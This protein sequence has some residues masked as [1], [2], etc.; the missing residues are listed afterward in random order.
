RSVVGIR[1]EVERTLSVRV[2]A[3]TPLVLT[4]CSMTSVTGPLRHFA[5]TSDVCR[6][7]AKADMNRQARS[8]T[9]I[10][11]DPGA[12]MN[13][14]CLAAMHGGPPKIHS[15]RASA[16]GELIRRRDLSYGDSRR[17]P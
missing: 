3:R 8:A 7:R 4:K 14:E 12:D 5:A 15:L 13:R 17:P 2:Y 16:V 11:N 9:S 10:A 1:S 6:F